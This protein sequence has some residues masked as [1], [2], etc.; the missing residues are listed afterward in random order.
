MIYYKIATSLETKITALYVM[1]VND[2]GSLGAKDNTD[3]HVIL[4]LI[5]HQT[6]IWQLE[7]TTQE[8]KYK[9]FKNMQI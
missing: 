8:F 6:C 3:Y 9:Y 2:S 5:I 7:I 4:G 1:Y